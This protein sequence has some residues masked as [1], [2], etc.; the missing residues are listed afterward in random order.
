MTESQKGAQAG[1]SPQ[2]TSNST[3]AVSEA[4]RQTPAYDPLQPGFGFRMM[5][6]PPP[7]PAAPAPQVPADE[8][9]LPAPVPAEQVTVTVTAASETPEE[10]GE[11]SHRH[12]AKHQKAP[13]SQL[14]DER[15]P[16]RLLSTKRGVVRF[17][18]FTVITAGVYTLFFF[19]GISED[20]N[21]L[22]CR[23]DGKR[24]PNLLLLPLITVLTLGIGYFVYWHRLSAR[25]REELWRR[26]GDYRFGPKTFWGWGVL[27]LLLAVGP[28]V[29][30]HKLCVA[31]NKLST[32]YNMHG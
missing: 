10:S 9:Q 18:F 21:L 17:V 1:N 20:M 30:L 14:A 27:G 12:R 26:R 4:G 7:Q 19:S 22:A 29:Y 31:L 23:H 32:D 8:M 25:I 2:N 24:T 11:K 6:E 15:A 13:E 28:L 5:A 16:K 3:Q